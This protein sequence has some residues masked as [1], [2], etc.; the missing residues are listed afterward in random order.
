MRSALALPAFASALVLSL[1][2]VGCSVSAPGTGG[3][4]GPGP[5][6]PGS[7]IPPRPNYTESADGTVEAVGYVG[8]S[9]L[10]GGFWAIY[11]SAPGP[12]STPRPK[13][14]AVLLPGKVAEPAIAALDGSLVTLT[15]RARKGA[16]I[17]MAGP[18]VLVDTIG[19]IRRVR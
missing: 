15:G 3:P 18:E 13:I 5:S 16:S 9:D 1:V 14:V 10:E 8:R 11:D 19:G 7:S 4:S 2:L 6:G 17:R 12:S